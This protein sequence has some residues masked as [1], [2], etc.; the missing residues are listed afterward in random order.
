MTLQDL[1]KR[2]LV[3]SGQ[4]LL[5]QAGLDTIEMNTDS[6]QLMVGNC[7][8]I[9][10]SYDPLDRRFNVISDFTS[11]TFIGGDWEIPVFIA[12]IIPV[13]IS[14]LP[15]Y[16]QNWMTWQGKGFGD[17]FNPLSAIW[18]Y[19]RPTLTFEYSGTFTVWATYNRPFIRFTGNWATTT[20]Y[21]TEETVD[22][23][24][25]GGVTYACIQSHTSAANNEPGVG[26]NWNS[27]WSVYPYT[28]K[29]NLTA[30]YY[31]LPDVTTKDRRFLKLVLG[32]FM[33]SLGIS[34]NTF[35]LSEVPV[36]SNSEK[37]ISRGED[38]EEKAMKEME[39]QGKWW[40]AQA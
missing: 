18:R 28:P 27:F 33:Q 34:R 7:L 25:N 30:P 20:S 16:F 3:E 35:I 5:L 38:L 1:F 11:Y 15:W 10:N 9:Y 22:V 8:E 37:L 17:E 6:F 4:F 24:K 19:N 21:N 23:V 2:M 31:D 12:E 39:E 29:S 13:V 14:G 36:T 32:K 40:I 26:A